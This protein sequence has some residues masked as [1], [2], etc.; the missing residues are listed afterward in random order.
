MILAI[1]PF[2]MLKTTLCK[3]WTSI[4]ISMAYIC[5]HKNIMLGSR[6]SCGF[7]KIKIFICLFTCLFIWGGGKILVDGWVKHWWGVGLLDRNFKIFGYQGIPCILPQFR[8]LSLYFCKCNPLCLWLIEPLP[9]G[10][11]APLKLPRLIC[12]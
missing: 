7:W 2:V 12:E 6:L 9:L 10:R 8:T 1:Q 5:I 11:K 3:Y 4:K